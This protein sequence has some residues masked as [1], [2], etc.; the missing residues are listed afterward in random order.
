MT[1]D[2]L[3]R[4]VRAGAWYVPPVRP[5]SEW[6][7]ESIV[8]PNLNISPRPGPFRFSE[9]P[10]LRGIVN[11][12]QDP[13]VK[14]IVIKA[15]SQAGKSTGL[16]ICLYWIIDEDP[17]PTLYVMPRRDDC[18]EVAKKYVEPVLRASPAMRSHLTGSS[19]DLQRAWF[20]FDRMT[21]YFAGSNSPADLAARPIRYL[22][23]DEENK[24]PPF[25][26]AEADPI[27]LATQRT[28]TFWDSKIIR[29][30]TPTT[31]DGSISIAYAEGDKREYWVPCPL[32]G[33]YQT[34]KFRAGLRWPREERNPDVIERQGLAWYECEKC[35]GE[36]REGQKRGMLERGVWVREGESVGD[37]GGVMRSAPHNATAS[38]MFSALYSTFVSWSHIAA[39]WLRA[40]GNLG[41]MMHFVNSTLAEEWEERELSPDAKDVKKT[42]G[43]YEAG[44]VPAEAVF[45]TAGVD[46]QKGYFVYVIRAWGPNFESWGVAAGDANSWGEVVERIV[47][48]RYESAA[49]G[50]PPLFVR[51]A[52]VDSGYEAEEV[53]GH[54]SEYGDVLLPCKGEGERKTPAGYRMV[55]VN[56]ESRALRLVWVNGD[57]FKD[58]LW[59]MIK[60]TPVL[61]HNPRGTSEAFVNQICAEKKIRVV[62]R[63]TGA[64]AYKW[65]PVE[66]GA[67][68]HFLDAEVYCMCAAELCGAALFDRPKVAAPPRRKRPGPSGAGRASS[69]KW[70]NI[71]R[72]WM[73]RTGHD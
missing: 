33:H 46:V 11:T 57:Y 3:L 47:D 62:S 72:N 14:A 10:Y 15:A 7:E 66:K 8:L 38:F 19:D 16:R 45:L 52:F 21:M 20:A 64:V 61:W 25:A 65:T 53:Y 68:N 59:R 44:R 49:P 5:V 34:L 35:K 12:L 22:V 31:Q 4:R 41:R 1:A 54:C 23:I 48:A 56:K 39:D 37:D 55:T 71:P 30:S 42:I 69:S 73:G 2:E 40:Q 28:V 63:K 17:G 29:C 26:G 43:G 6:A 36:I 13:T 51:L 24:F 18:Y 32:C 58:R 50:T 70:M 9:S 67:P 27:S 60:S